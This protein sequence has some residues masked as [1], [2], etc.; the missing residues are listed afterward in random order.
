MTSYICFDEIDF[1]TGIRQ[2]DGLLCVRWPNGIYLK[3]IKTWAYHL[4][5]E[6]D[7]YIFQHQIFRKNNTELL[8]WIERWSKDIS[9]GKYNS[10]KTEREKILDIVRKRSLTSYMNN[11]KWHELKTAIT[12]KLPFQPPYDYKTLFDDNDYINKDYVQHLINNEGP[13]DFCSFDSESFYFLNYKAIEWL[14]VRPCFYKLEG[15]ALV[16]KKVWYDC[17]KEFLQILKIY[18]IPYELENGVYTIYG[19]K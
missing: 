5:I 14:K 4:T 2:T 1:G 16:K 8:L 18:S 10:K 15:G 19:Y 6:R 11:T 13:N 17:E 7:R 9:S 12:E 3:L